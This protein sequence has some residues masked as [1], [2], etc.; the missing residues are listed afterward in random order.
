MAGFTTRTIH[1]LHDV[2]L[3]AV[4]PPIHTA[5]TFLQP[6]EG[7]EG[8]F[9]YQ[10]GSNPT[11]TD[12]ETTLAALEGARHSFAFAT[13]MAATGA[14][15]GTLHAGDS[16][17]MGLPVYGGNYRWATIELPKRG[18]T[19]HF[20]DDLNRLSD[21]DFDESTRIVFLE[22]P[23]N[24]TLRVTDIR[25]VVELAH[26]HGAMVVVDNTFLT[27]YLQRPLELG[28]DVTVQSATKYLGGHGDLLGGV[29][30][31]NDDE[32]AQQVHLAQMVSGGVLSPI[33]SYRLIQSVKT[34]GIRLDRQQ[35]NAHRIVEFLRG[36]D[37]VA[38]VLV[39]GSFDEEEARI[40]E[41]QADGLGGLF[42]FELLPGKDVRAFLGRLE[43][44][45]FAVSLGGIESLIC[46]PASMTHGAYS[47][48]DRE[49]AHLSENLLR[50]A[51]GIE[52]VEDLIADLA[53]A[54][55]AA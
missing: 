11:R 55:N 39:P 38:R 43:I 15:L 6:T 32:M 22:T 33:D 29:V 2:A 49:L 17:I 14:V 41:A 50:V 31:T 18:I 51:V 26:R 27:P 5:S 34:L 44:F 54:L 4:V 8:P 3:G 19:T 25:R 30:S 53:Q 1:A 28:A 45:G 23:S 40:Q 12:A 52:D 24:P 21:E 47:P 42:S 35:E 46:L 36:R 9:E 20:H 48:E 7:G 13:G 16:V 10:R 37:E